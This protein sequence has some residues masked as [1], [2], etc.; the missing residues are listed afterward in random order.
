M[1]G[2]MLR[3]LSRYTLIPAAWLG[4]ALSGCQSGERPRDTGEVRAGADTFNPPPTT[5]SA[6]G[7]GQLSDANIVALLDEANAADS[8]AGA[9]ARDKATSKEV[10]DFAKLMMAEHHALRVQ[11]Q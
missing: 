5:E 7:S 4:L 2:H 1:G 10:K 3:A 6:V 9:L 11:G 8:T